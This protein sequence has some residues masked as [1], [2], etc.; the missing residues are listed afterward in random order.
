MFSPIRLPA[1]AVAV[2]L[3]GVGLLPVATP[4][5]AQTSYPDRAIRLVVPFP[6]GGSTDVL[7][8]VMAE[9]LRAEFNQPVIV[10]NKPGAAG[11]IGGDFVARAPADGYTLL[12]A[13]A[14]PTVINPHL[15]SKMSFDPAK[16]LVPVTQLVI[17]HNVMAIHPSIPATNVQEFVTWAKANPA[18]A[19]CASPG[20]GTPAHL[21]CELFN[22]RTGTAMTHVPY[23]GSG[24][25]V[26]DLIAGH[27]AVMIDNMP[28]LLPHARNGRLR[29]LA[30]SGEQ[31]ATG[32]PELPTVIESGIP[33][34]NIVA[35]KA[36]MAP[37]G[38]PRPIIDRLQQTAAKIIARPDIKA[39][40]IE[41]GSEPVASTPE[42][43]AELIVRETASWG[44]LVKSTGARND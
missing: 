29:A 15:Y 42:A 28:A 12:A 39:R 33:G 7:A 19:I 18:K 37:A 22:Q 41:A 8:R 1:L 40:L 27:A 10:E 20:S 32:A 6:P 3:T 26:A 36:L 14:G 31:R 43:F 44:A 2:A 30:V 9:A 34:F 4:A 21:A 13:A 25:A 23:K 24:P 16:D 17:D 11:N 5:A 38:T 35:W